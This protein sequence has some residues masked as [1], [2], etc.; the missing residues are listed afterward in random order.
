MDVCQA[1]KGDMDMTPM[2]AGGLPDWRV[3]SDE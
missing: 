1:E 2:Q 3:T